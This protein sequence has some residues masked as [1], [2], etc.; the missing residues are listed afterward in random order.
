MCF[1][2]IPSNGIYEIDMHNLVPNVNSIYNVSNKRVK[3]NLDSTYLWHCRLAH[4]N[5]KR[6]KQLQQDG[7]LNSMDDESFDQCESC[8][9]GKMT[10]KHCPHSNE[11]AKDLLG[12]IHT[13]VCGPL[14]YVLRQ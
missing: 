8:L 9:S 10:K 6:I 12:I 1:I 2:V 5:K 3:R 11:K 4:I 13:D 14:R 7:L